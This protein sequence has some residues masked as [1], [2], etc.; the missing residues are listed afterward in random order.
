M[1]TPLKKSINRVVIAGGGTAG[2]LAASLLKKLLG[3]AIEITLV[4][5]EAIGTVGVGEATIPPIRLVN[6]VLGIDEAQFIHD[7]KATVKLAIRFENWKTKGESYYHTFG[8]PGRSMAFCHFHH[9]W[10]KARQQGFKKRFV[11][12]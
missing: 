5:S 8:A 12:L 6:Q 11:G 1:L 4:E 3:Q 7:T 10:V 2:W 9:Y